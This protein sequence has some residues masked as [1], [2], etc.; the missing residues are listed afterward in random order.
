M[1]IFITTTLDKLIFASLTTGHTWH[2]AVITGDIFIFLPN[3]ELFFSFL[4]IL[5][6]RVSRFAS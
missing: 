1:S 2:Q 6:A 5:R 4:S 3:S